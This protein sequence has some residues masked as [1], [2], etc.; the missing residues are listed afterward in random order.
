MTFFSVWF[1]LVA[2]VISTVL[3][4]MLHFVKD[5]FTFCSPFLCCVAL[6]SLSYC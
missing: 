6:L 1:F 4:K 3:F 2:V 5:V